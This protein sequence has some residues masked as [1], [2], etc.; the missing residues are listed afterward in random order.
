MDHRVLLHVYGLL[1][2]TVRRQLMDVI[3]LVGQF[4]LLVKY[5]WQTSDMRDYDL[6]LGSKL[7]VY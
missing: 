4:L 1:R 7:S 5:I 3:T 2:A 6:L